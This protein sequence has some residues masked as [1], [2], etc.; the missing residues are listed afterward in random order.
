MPPYQPVFK[1]VELECAGV[2]LEKPSTES[3]VAT[4]VIH[5]IGIHVTLM[6]PKQC[7]FPPSKSSTAMAILAGPVVPA[8]Q[9]VPV[10]PPLLLPTQPG[11]T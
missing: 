2:S 8:M 1:V 9:N 4:Y 11:S 6:R 3:T 7:N 5:I 10:Q